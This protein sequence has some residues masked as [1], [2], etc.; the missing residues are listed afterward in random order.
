MVIRYAVRRS[1]TRARAARAAGVI[2]M[3]VPEASAPSA[4]RRVGLRPWSGDQGRDGDWVERRDA[5]TGDDQADGDQLR[6][7]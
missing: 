1:M 6:V 2:R 5:D 4:A 7:C 3:A